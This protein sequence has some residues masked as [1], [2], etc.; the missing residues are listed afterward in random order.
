M[1]EKCPEEPER[2]LLRMRVHK[3]VWSLLPHDTAYLRAL[4]SSLEGQLNLA[5]GTENDKIRKNQNFK[6]I[7]EQF[8]HSL[9]PA[10]LLLLC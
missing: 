10:L 3:F 1:Q 2:L 9:N 4:K 7:T 8:E 6:I 5:H